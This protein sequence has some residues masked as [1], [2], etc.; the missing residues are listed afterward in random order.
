MAHSGTPG[1]VRPEVDFAAD[2]VYHRRPSV[3]YHDRD[4]RAERAGCTAWQPHGQVVYNLP[5]L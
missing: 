5:D 3:R 1:R 4:P 2:G